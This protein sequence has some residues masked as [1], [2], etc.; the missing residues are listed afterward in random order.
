MNKEGRERERERKGK[1]RKK[2]GRK[3]R[4]DVTHV[5]VTWKN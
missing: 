3:S 5:V 2:R 1:E 4:Y